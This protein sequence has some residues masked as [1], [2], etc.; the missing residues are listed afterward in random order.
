MSPT[1]DRKPMSSKTF[2][3]FRAVVVFPM[4]TNGLAR[5]IGSGLQKITPWTPEDKLCGN[6]LA[7]IE[8]LS[9]HPARDL[10]VS[11]KLWKEQTR[12]DLRMNWSYPS[13]K[14]C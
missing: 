1:K 7:R 4:P 11:L 6:L 5:I 3:I 8:S 12:S 13:A 9:F 14:F 2:P 10:L